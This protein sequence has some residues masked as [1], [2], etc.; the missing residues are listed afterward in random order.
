MMPQGIIRSLPG[1][2]S[3]HHPAPARECLKASPVLKG[4]NPNK[5]KC[6][7]FNNVRQRFYQVP[8]LQDL[9]KTVKPEVI[10]EFLKAAAQYRLL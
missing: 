3:G 2:A 5:P 4:L 1:N 7:D 8:S 9:F 10:L 6:V